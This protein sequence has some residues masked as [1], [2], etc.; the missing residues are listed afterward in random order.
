MTSRERETSEVA[1]TPNYG[2]RDSKVRRIGWPLWRHGRPSPTSPFRSQTA[3]N[4]AW[5]G[6]SQIFPQLVAIAAVPILVHRLGVDGYGVWALTGTILV[7]AVS[8]D[9]G[10][11]SSA[12][13]FYVMYRARQDVRTSA[14]FSALLLGTTFIFAALLVILGPL[15]SHVAQS[16]AHIP[17]Q[18]RADADFTFRNVGFL[19]GLALWSNILTA[20]L[21]ASNRFRTIAVNTAVA[22]IVYLALILA[23]SDTLTV[24]LVFK[25]AMVQLTILNLL[26]AFACREHL[27]KLRPQ[28]LELRLQREFF[29][30][31]WRAQ[32]MNVSS[33]AILQTDSLFVAAL[34]PIEQLGYLAIGTQI[35]SAARSLPL[36]GMA[37]LLTRMTRV[38]SAKGMA[39]ATSFAS[40]VNRIWFLGISRYGLV[41]VISSWFIVLGWT[42]PLVEAQFVA[43]VLLAGNTLNLV[44]AVATAYCRSVG[45]P[46]IEAKYGLALVALNLV[47]SWPSTYFAGLA[48]AVTSTAIVQLLAVVYF[49]RLLRKQIPTFRW[50]ARGVGVFGMVGVAAATLGIQSTTLLLPHPSMLALFAAVAGAAAVAA[51]ALWRTV[52]PAIRRIDLD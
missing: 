16:I 32:V 14:R 11:T 37:P 3:L 1:G 20:Y 38:Y 23:L 21:R 31:A 15:L 48:G 47:V 10:I 2:N 30:Y 41:A 39:A 19:A 29:S 17:P 9:G 40:S 8:F 44:T 50:G 6:L 18:F 26:G 22:Q 51:I 25:C 7:F 28:V 46:G 42:G 27:Y 45:K 35:A 52:V 49:Y 5:N 43:V 4:S 12:Q 13:R 36:F 34:L 24:S 33:L